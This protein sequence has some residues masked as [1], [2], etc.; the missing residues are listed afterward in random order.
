M[1]R[2]SFLGCLLGLTVGDAMG[3]PVEGLK[4]GHIQQLTGGVEGYLDP[5][6]LFPERPARW[7]PDHFSAAAE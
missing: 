7:G 5:V 6:K 1:G 4:A 3:A 2:D